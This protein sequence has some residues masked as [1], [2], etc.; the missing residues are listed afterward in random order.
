MLIKGKIRQEH[1]TILNIYAPKARAP[2]FA[3]ETVLLLKLYI[4]SNTS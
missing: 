4:D 1:I 2:K 3:K